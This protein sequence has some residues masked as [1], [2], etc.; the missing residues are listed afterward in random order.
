MLSCLVGYISEEVIDTW[1]LDSQS[2]KELKTS[3]TYILKFLDRVRN[4]L[5]KGQLSRILYDAENTEIQCIPKWDAK[6]QKELVIEKQLNELCQVRRGALESLAEK[7]L[8]NC[9]PCKET[10][11][12]EC[13]L[14]QSFIELN[15]P[16][17][18]F[19]DQHP[20]CPYKM[21][22]VKP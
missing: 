15:I 16:P 2:T 18:E 7:A 13:M 4:A 3:K 21:N 19:E 22:E 14:R 6:I 8:G 11:C 10:N 1:N 12:Q 5:D 17:L 20:D 9:D